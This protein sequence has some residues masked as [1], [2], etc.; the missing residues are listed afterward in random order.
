MPDFL[1]LL[2]VEINLHNP[3]RSSVLHFLLIGF[4]SLKNLRSMNSLVRYTISKWWF[5]RNCYSCKCKNQTLLRKQRR[6][7]GS[8]FVFIW[9]LNPLMLDNKIIGFQ[10]SYFYNNGFS[11]NALSI[12]IRWNASLHNYLFDLITQII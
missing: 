7:K 10:F 6:M 8:I 3:I 12:K 11:Y 5:S 1:T 2:G 4:P 9:Q